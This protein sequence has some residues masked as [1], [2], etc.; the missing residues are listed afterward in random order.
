MRE[1]IEA[2]RFQAIDPIFGKSSRE[3]VAERETGIRTGMKH[4]T[5]LAL[6]YVNP[7]DRVKAFLY[8]LDRAQQDGWI[9]RELASLR[10]LVADFRTNAPEAPVWIEINVSPLVSRADY[11]WKKQDKLKKK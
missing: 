3:I 5:N 4:L 9:P 8:F 2:I 7:N 11:F 10:E 6:V 1:R